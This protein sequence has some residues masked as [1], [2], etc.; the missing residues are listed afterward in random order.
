[1]KKILYVLLFVLLIPFTINAFQIDSLGLK[2]N[3]INNLTIETRNE[4]KD[5]YTYYINNMYAQGENDDYKM[6]IR[7]IQNPL[8]HN[9]EPNVDLMDDVFGLIENVNTNEY[10]FITN[11]NYKWIRLLYKTKNENIPLLEY[12]LSYKNI[13]ITITFQSKKS[14]FTIEEK[15]IMD[16]FVNSIS[17]TGE[18]KVE[19]S[20]IYPDGI[21]TK[22]KTI[23]H[24]LIIEII[25][26][27]IA[28]VITYYVFRKKR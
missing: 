28:I 20:H 24:F 6:Y 8:D 12:Y 22:P 2:G 14:D 19:V 21:D 5:S 17:L 9:F 23:K 7:A 26:C 10:S 15:T 1:M 13:F 4:M 18:G 27:V 11:K 25:I 3:D 16:E